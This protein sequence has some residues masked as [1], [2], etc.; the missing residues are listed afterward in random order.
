M[1]WP[2]VNVSPLE[3]R[4]ALDVDSIALT[5]RTLNDA[6]WV[7]IRS[8][9]APVLTLSSTF[10]LTSNDKRSTCIAIV[11]FEIQYKSRAVGRQNTTSINH[12]PSLTN[13]TSITHLDP[14]ALRTRSTANCQE[15]AGTGALNGE[16]QRYIGS[17]L[18]RFGCGI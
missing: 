9:E 7:D 1:D 18:D 16:W 17:F 14:N 2:N 5:F 10:V 4:I 11:T 8:E 13:D 6:N 3:F 12:K 15:L